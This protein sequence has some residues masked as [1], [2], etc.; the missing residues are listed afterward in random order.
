MIA[1][2]C[3]AK[4]WFPKAEEYRYVVLSAFSSYEGLKEFV[5]F[6]Y[7]EAKYKY[8]EIHSVSNAVA[9]ATTD[10]NSNPEDW[11]WDYLWQID[12]ELLPNE[13]VEAGYN[14]KIPATDISGRYVGTAILT[15]EDHY[16]SKE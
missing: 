1:E 6:E 16:F 12:P 3:E 7:D 9:W 8:W 15:Y 2:R 10:V 13:V 14:L 5:A 4:L 11:E